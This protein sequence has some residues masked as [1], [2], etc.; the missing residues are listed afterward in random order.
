M[1]LNFKF[2]FDFHIC[3]SKENGPIC[4]AK[5]KSLKLHFKLSAEKIKFSQ[6]GILKHIRRIFSN[7]L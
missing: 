5:S 2:L 7:Y 1:N 6:K 4:F 3:I